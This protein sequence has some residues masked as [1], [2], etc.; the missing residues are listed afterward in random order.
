M[1][2]CGLV[3]VAGAVVIVV[4]CV[5]AGGTVGG[6]VPSGLPGV[7]TALIGTAVGFLVGAAAA[8]VMLG[9]VLGS[10]ARLAPPAFNEQQ[11]P[12]PT[13]DEPARP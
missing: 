13:A 9:A 12:T 10:R 8:W 2:Q 4:M 11:E 6:F 5:V 7:V 3:A 1:R